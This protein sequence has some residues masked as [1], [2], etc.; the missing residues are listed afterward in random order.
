M[1]LNELCIFVGY[2]D[3]VESE[4]DRYYLKKES[5]DRLTKNFSAEDLFCNGQCPFW[6]FLV[7]I[8]SNRVVRKSLNKKTVCFL[9]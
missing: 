5:C 8:E 2:V 1:N 4:S 9:R 6:V 7:E 3:L